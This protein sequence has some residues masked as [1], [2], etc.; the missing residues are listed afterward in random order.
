MGP[1]VIPVPKLRVPEE[2]WAVTL[3]EFATEPAAQVGLKRPRV[4]PLSEE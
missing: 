3:Q 2:S 1:P 4:T